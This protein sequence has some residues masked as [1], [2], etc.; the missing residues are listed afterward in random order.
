MKYPFDRCYHA[1]SHHLAAR[2]FREGSLAAPIGKYTEW[3][4]QGCW[5]GIGF[6]Y[7]VANMA[8]QRSRDTNLIEFT[9]ETVLQ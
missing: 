5:V 4:A 9:H 7:H 8:I 6:A 1:K 2:P 3:D